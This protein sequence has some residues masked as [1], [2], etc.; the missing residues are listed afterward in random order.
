MGG[1][2]SCVLKNQ[3]DL[4]FIHQFLVKIHTRGVFYL[5][6]MGQH[7]YSIL[8]QRWIPFRDVPCDVKPITCWFDKI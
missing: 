3:P 7:V 4:V 1:I 2:V 8:L 6:Q 5:L